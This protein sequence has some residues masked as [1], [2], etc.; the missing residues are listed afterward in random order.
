MR[1]GVLGPDNSPKKKLGKLGPDSPHTS[2]V[3]RGTPGQPAGQNLVVEEYAYSAAQNNYQREVGNRAPELVHRKPKPGEAAPLPGERG[4]VFYKDATP[5][6]DHFMQFRVKLPRNLRQALARDPPPLELTLCFAPNHDSDEYVVVAD[7]SHLRKCDAPRGE[8]RGSRDNVLGAILRFRVELGSC[9]QG[10]KRFVIKASLASEEAQKRG[11]PALEPAYT[12]PVYVASKV[13]RSRMAAHQNQQ[14][15]DDASVSPHPLPHA[16]RQR[17]GQ[18]S[19]PRMPSLQAVDL[20]QLQ[21]RLD[22]LEELIVD[23]VLP[24]LDRL[25]D[26]LASTAPVEEEEMPASQDSLAQL[27]RAPTWSD[28][29]SA[30]GT[31]MGDARD[32]LLSFSLSQDSQDAPPPPPAR[33]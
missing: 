26:R 19:A 32:A 3:R 28:A 27:V 31:G 30:M 6:A 22:G 11:L 10:D 8:P 16:R 14:V 20:S 24:I 12:T 13:K 21:A 15:D 33:D 7:Q 1:R 25:D 4:E 29:V 9:R 5:K 18:P 17:I 2:M 23:R